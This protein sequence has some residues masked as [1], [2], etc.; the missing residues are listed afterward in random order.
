MYVCR[1]NRKTETQEIYEF[2]RILTNPWYVSGERKPFTSFR[3]HS[4][5]LT[6]LTKYSRHSPR[7]KDQIHD[8]Q[9]DLTPLLTCFSHPLRSLCEYN[10]FSRKIPLFPFSSYTSFI[11]LTDPATCVPAHYSVTDCTWRSSSTVANT[12]SSVTVK[13]LRIRSWADAFNQSF[14]WASTQYYSAHA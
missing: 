9:D 7:I 14:S 1:V 6:P 10:T 13:T 4:P 2:P 3:N 8:E 5:K 11:P 12:L